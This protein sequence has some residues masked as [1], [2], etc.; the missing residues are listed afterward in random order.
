M[1]AIFDLFKFLFLGCLYLIL[2]IACISWVYQGY[3]YLSEQAETKPSQSEDRAHPCE[4]A[5]N[6]ANYQDRYTNWAPGNVGR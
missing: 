2:G 5:H 3:T 4:K 1:K 6:C